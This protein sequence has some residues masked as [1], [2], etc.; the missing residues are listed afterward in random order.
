[1]LMAITKPRFSSTI[2]RV[3]PSR[4]VDDKLD[5]ID[6]KI[7]CE[8]AF[9]RRYEELS[10]RQVSPSTIGRKLAIDEKTVRVRIRA[11]EKEGFIKYY[12][13]LPNLSLFGLNYVSIF[14]LESFNI[15]TKRRLLDDIRKTP[16]IL[17]ASDY[18]GHMIS[19]VISSPSS[20]ESEKLT[21]QITRRFELKRI[22]L[23]ERALEKPAQRLD[24]L[25]WQIISKLRYD[26]RRKSKEVAESLSITRRVAE[27][28]IKRLLQSGAMVIKAITDPQK[29]AGLIFYE[30]EASVDQEDQSSVASSFNES[31]REK[32]W[33]MKL[34]NRTV[35]IN[36]FCFS[37]K[38]PEEAATDLL[39]IKGVRA[40]S[41]FVLKE[42]TEPPRPSWLDE[43][44]EKKIA[45]AR[46]L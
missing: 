20:L 36:L 1:V 23:D 17:E 38:E 35:L 41:L 5:A 19:V 44:I 40:V 6:V 8:M 15:A 11:M 14:R 9:G 18:L 34:T 37:L 22:N 4:Q 45:M 31:Y 16:R 7:F 29:Q 24:K 32:I 21:E 26:A 42:T 10:N 27:F 25:D 13:D 30:L 33:S 43:L 3:S 46:T 12:Q 39:R 28:R 2:L